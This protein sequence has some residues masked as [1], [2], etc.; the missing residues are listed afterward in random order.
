MRPMTWIFIVIYTATLAAFVPMWRDQRDA[1]RHDLAAAR[2][3]LYDIRDSLSFCRA[4]PRVFIPR[5]AAD[6][7]LADRGGAWVSVWTNNQS[8]IWMPPFN[9]ETWQFILASQKQP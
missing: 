4:E 1:A 7:V 3:S 6:S 9:R 2:D 8:G 5:A